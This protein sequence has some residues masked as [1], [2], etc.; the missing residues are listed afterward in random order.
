[1]KLEFRFISASRANRKNPR[2]NDGREG[3]A[4]GFKSGGPHCHDW[5]KTRWIDV[6]ERP[7]HCT[8]TDRDLDTN[9]VSI[10]YVVLSHFIGT[11]VRRHASDRMFCPKTFDTNEKVVTIK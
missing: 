2:G 11:D 10:Y 8:N 7:T 5:H 9:T 3:I 4:N 6:F 1:M